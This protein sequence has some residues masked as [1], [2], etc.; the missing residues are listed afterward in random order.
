MKTLIATN[1]ASSQ[2]ELIDIGFLVLKLETLSEISTEF[3]T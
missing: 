1:R 3:H 2:R